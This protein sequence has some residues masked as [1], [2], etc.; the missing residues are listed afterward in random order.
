MT[1]TSLVAI[2]L[3]VFLPLEVYSL[4]QITVL[5]LLSLVLMEEKSLLIPYMEA[6]KVSTLQI[7]A[8]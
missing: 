7:I 4:A 6:Q 5:R 2:S 3:L 8:S 1:A